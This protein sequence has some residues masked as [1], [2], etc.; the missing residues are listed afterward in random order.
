MEWSV[1]FEMSGVR[2]AGPL[3]AR[4]DRLPQGGW[5]RSE[6]TPQTRP[7]TESPLTVRNPGFE[8]PFSH[9]IPPFPGTGAILE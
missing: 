9:P 3:A 1:K 6:A 7:P 4:C 8:T 2:L 5:R